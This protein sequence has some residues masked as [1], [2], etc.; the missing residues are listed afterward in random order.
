[1][2]ISVD[3][4][5]SIVIWIAAVK[6]SVVILTVSSC[7]VAVKPDVTEIVDGFMLL[8]DDD[9]LSL[10]VVSMGVDSVVTVVFDVVLSSAVVLLIGISLVSL[11]TSCEIPVV[12]SD[13]KL[14]GGEVSSVCA[15][16]CSV[17]EVVG[18]FV[19]IAAG[20]VVGI[21]VGSVVSTVV[22]SAVW[23]VVGLVMGAVVGSALISVVC[24]VLCCVVVI[25]VASVVASVVIRVVISVDSSAVVGAGGM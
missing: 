8:S 23:T 4:N 12:E 3:R 2:D 9:S 13:A 5:V 18:S 15:P 10:A 22:G 1:M 21:M 11:V 24:I 14:V 17:I 19:G 25:V 6:S 20:S 7:G 16:F